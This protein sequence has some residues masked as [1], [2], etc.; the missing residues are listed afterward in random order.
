MNKIK[1]PTLVELYTC[2]WNIYLYAEYV[3]TGLKV[4]HSSVL[5]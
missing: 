1:S 4:G 3:S 2:I 5:K